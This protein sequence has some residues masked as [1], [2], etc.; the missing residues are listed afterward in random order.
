MGIG[1]G[2]G[3]IPARGV[4]W[5]FDLDKIWI[6]LAKGWG[7]PGIFGRILLRDRIQP[8]PGGRRWPS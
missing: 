5:G 3:D 2:K 7:S 6:L 4:V 1:R 8:K